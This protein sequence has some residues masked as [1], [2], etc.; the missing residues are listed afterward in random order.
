MSAIATLPTFDT[1]EPPPVPL[2][3]FTVEQYH[4]MIDAGVFA[5]DDRFELLE[6]WIVAKMPRN[7][8]HDVAIVLAQE[9]LQTRR[10]AGWHIR[11]QSAITLVD[12]QPEPDL[13]I[14]RGSARDYLAR[15]PGPGDVALVVEVADATLDRDLGLKRR[16]YARAGLPAYWVLNLVDRRVEAHG[17]P[18]GPVAAG[19]PSYCTIAIYGPGDSVPMAIGDAAPTLLPVDSLLP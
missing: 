6:G 12:S 10:P 3:R 15:H 1:S 19:E 2:A 11:N 17:D 7:P 9:A 8:P 5:S 14:V 18:T 16:I 4:Q 13:A